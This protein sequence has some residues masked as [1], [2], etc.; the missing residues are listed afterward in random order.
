MVKSGMFLANHGFGAGFC[1]RRVFEK[2]VGTATDRR[3]LCQ[4]RVLLVILKMGVLTSLHGHSG[5]TLSHV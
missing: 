1:G 2:N 5:C 4:S 3:A